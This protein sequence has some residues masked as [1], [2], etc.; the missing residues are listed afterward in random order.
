MN[1]AFDRKRNTTDVTN[2]E[3]SEVFVLLFLQ[4]LGLLWDEPVPARRRVILDLRW[5][6]HDAKCYK[7]RSFRVCRDKVSVLGP[8]LS[9]DVMEV[10]GGRV[11][12]WQ[13]RD[14]ISS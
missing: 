4:R 6:V 14:T 1:V 3:T 11:P 2:R 10:G 7:F 13:P 12:G 8:S 9:I 5:A